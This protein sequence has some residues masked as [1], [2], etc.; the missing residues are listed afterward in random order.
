MMVCHDCL[1]DPK[2][3]PEQ[4]KDFDVAGAICDCL[5]VLITQEQLNK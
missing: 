2:L 1:R 3:K 5:E 4:V